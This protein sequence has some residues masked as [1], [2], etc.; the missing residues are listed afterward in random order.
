MYFSHICDFRPMTQPN[1]LKTQIFDP[2][3]TCNPTQPEG[4]P[5]RRTTLPYPDPTPSLFSIFIPQ[6]DSDVT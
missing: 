4:Q 6:P 3:P 1:P 2:F 5:N